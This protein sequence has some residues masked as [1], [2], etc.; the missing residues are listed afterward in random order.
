YRECNSEGNW[1]AGGGTGGSQRT[2]RL[3]H[4]SFTC[5]YGR[6]EGEPAPSQTDAQCT[7]LAKTTRICSPDYDQGRTLGEIDGPG[8]LELGVIP[9]AEPVAGRGRRRTEKLGNSRKIC[10]QSGR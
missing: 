8:I 2:I 9:G 7:F 1:R 4:S 5:D 10:A 6:A 3:E